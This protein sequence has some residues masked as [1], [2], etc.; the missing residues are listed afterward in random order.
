MKS[1]GI[2]IVAVLLASPAAYAKRGGG[3]FKDLDLTKEQKQKLEA[4]R[5]DSKDDRK[6]NREAMKTARKALAEAA[7]GDASEAQLR[8]LFNSL[9]DLHKKNATARFEKLLKIRAILTPEQRKKIKMHKFGGPGNRGGKHGKRPDR[10][11]GDDE[12]LDE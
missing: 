1:L 12:G 6:D 8:T 5:A 7:K 4:M 11:N 2:L 3:W 9:Q 10:D